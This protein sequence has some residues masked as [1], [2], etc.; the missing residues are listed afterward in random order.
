M[1]Q[2]S[3]LPVNV[4]AIVPSVSV[5]LDGKDLK[6]VARGDDGNDYAMKTV[7]D[8]ETLPL[9]EWVCYSMW[10]ECGLPVPDCAVLVRRSDPPAFGS[11]I[12][13][14]SYQLPKGP[15]S[16]YT[17]AQYFRPHLADLGRLYPADAF[18]PNNDRHGRNVIFRQQL[19]GTTMVSIDF[20]R[21]WLQSGQPFGD[22][23]SLT[24][25][26]TAKWW[27]HFRDLMNVKADHDA[28]D[29][30]LALPDDWMLKTISQAPAEWSANINLTAVD[31]F[32][33][34]QR[35]ARATSAKMWL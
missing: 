25:S 33:R 14:Q 32:W 17:I 23:N 19:T 35:Q 5:G 31:D 18:L 2:L 7:A 9:S 29:K 26:H 3:L 20:S 22:M 8:S 1:A 12:E 6:W 21:A 11:R 13:L 15:A 34:N 10:G 4:T 28:L 16:F 24:G 30:I 27:H